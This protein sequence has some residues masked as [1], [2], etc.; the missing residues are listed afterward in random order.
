MQDVY[1]ANEALL[2]HL[3]DP[4]E[5]TW[6]AFRK[7]QGRCVRKQG[8]R[9]VGGPE[10]EEYFTPAAEALRSSLEGALEDDIADLDQPTVEEVQEQVEDDLR[11]EML[12]ILA[13]LVSGIYLAQLQ[14]TEE[15]VGMDLPVS[16]RHE[17]AM[18]RLAYGR[19]S[20]DAFERFSEETSDEII[21]IIGEM[22]REGRTPS[23]EQIVRRLRDDIAWE[24]REH[25][26][27][28]A[29]TEAWKIRQTARE[30]GYEQVMDQTGEDIVF[31][32]ETQNDT[33]VCEVC[34]T[35]SDGVGNGVTLDELRRIITQV[36]TNPRYGGS[37]GWQPSRDGN[38]PL[39]HPN[40]FTG[41]MEVLTKEGWKR[42]DECRGDETVATRRKKYG[43]QFEWQEPNAF[44]EKEAEE[45]AILDSEEVSFKMTPSHD[46]LYK[47]GGGYVQKDTLWNQL[48]KRERIHMPS[49][50]EE[51]AHGIQAG[52][53]LLGP[54]EKF[55]AKSD[56]R[57][58][59][60][61]ETVD[62]EDWARFLGIWMA[63]GSVSQDSHYHRV[64]IAA[65]DEEVRRDLVDLLDRMPF[66]Y[67]AGENDFTIV[68]KTLWEEFEHLRGDTPKRLPEY[69]FDWDQD[70][71]R[72]LL[73][74]YGKGDGTL[75]SRK[76][77]RDIWEYWS[78]SEELLDQFQAL[79]AMAGRASGKR[80]TREAGTEVPMPRGTVSKSKTLFNLKGRSTDTRS[81]N[82]D[83]VEIQEYN[84]TVYCF[85]VD[86]G[87]LLVRYE[88]KPFWT[89]NCRCRMVPKDD[90]DILEKALQ[91][92]RTVT[93]DEVLP[94]V[95]TLDAQ[96]ANGP[97]KHIALG[98]S[99]GR[100]ETTQND[101]D[102][103]LVYE[104]ALLPEVIGHAQMVGSLL[105]EIIQGL[106]VDIVV[107][108]WGEGLVRHGNLEDFPAGYGTS[109][110][111][112]RR[113]DYPITKPGWERVG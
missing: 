79:M 108:Q 87:S 83:D 89:G 111:Q 59:V 18:E 40:C 17:A 82:T 48:D 9:V 72:I 84:D 23:P 55:V 13:G 33:R 4:S 112:H 42:F 22:H 10:G 5:D 50:L 65:S 92:A 14:R 109:L 60:E 97:L 105:P 52:H 85:N 25:I 75:R 53:H 16:Q 11:T 110:P 51:G 101:V 62:L 6:D 86:N 12:I 45:I 7:A 8:P 113:Q 93:P 41:D 47:T 104:G 103:V 32:W 54:T 64:R 46:I 90:E 15:R 21:R 81:F 71:V 2:K 77:G 30:Q 107:E 95:Q 58:R 57:R 35:I 94:I 26:E 70:L 27:R 78:V 37:L 67:S 20:R 80:V 63:E 61:Y 36:S 106:P 56:S 34:Q 28:I 68:D 76:T 44:I 96:H 29:R 102:L 19:T 98:G 88:G 73:A 1:E 38:F 49:S 100:G 43:G 74:W 66:K 99:L 24:P 69:V 3:R 91:K 31:L 39:P